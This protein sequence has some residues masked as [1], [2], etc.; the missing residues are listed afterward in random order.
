MPK[1]QIK[2][3]PKFIEHSLVSSCFLLLQKK[4]EGGHCPKEAILLLQTVEPKQS[5]YLLPSLSKK[6]LTYL[7]V[8]KKQEACGKQVKRNASGGLREEK[9][10][11][12]SIS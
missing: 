1:I 5:H 8:Q 3:L 2:K 6:N 12:T 9:Y 4:G 7:P 11:K 10:R